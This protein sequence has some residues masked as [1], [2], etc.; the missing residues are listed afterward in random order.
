VSQ[1]IARQLRDAGV[2][3][4]FGVMGDGNMH[5]LAEYATLPGVRWCPAWHEA[6]AVGMADGYARAAGRD[7]AGRNSVGVAT[8]TMGPGLAQALA[9]LTAA[10]RTRSPVLVITAEPDHVSP[11]NAQDVDQQSWAAV[12]GARYRLVTEPADLGRALAETMAWARSGHPAV[13]A[14]ALSLMEKEGDSEAPPAARPTRTNRITGLEPAARLLAASR[15][16]L[17]LLGR[18]AELSGAVPAAVELGRKIG[19]CFL[20]TVPA[21][22]CLAD[23]GDPFDLG[24]TGTMAHP[25]ARRLAAEADVVL[26]V[27]TDLD[28][29]NTAG[30]SFFGAAHLIRI[31]IR[32]PA[33]LWH[34]DNDVTQITADATTALTQL[35]PQLPPGHRN[36]LRTPETAKL[37]AAEPARRAALAAAQPADGLNPWAV[38]AAI[39]AAVC[40]RAHLMTGVGHF[41]YFAAPYLSARPGRTF[42]FGYGFGLIG[43]GLPLAIGAAVANRPTVVIEGD[44]SFLMNP[45]ELQSAVRFGADLLVIVLNNEAYGS[46][47]HK[48]AIADLDPSAGAF[49]RPADLVAIAR[50]LG[51]D[52]RRADTM[53]ELRAGLAAFASCGGVRVLDVAIARSVMSEAYQR[54]HVR[55]KLPWSRER[56]DDTA[57]LRTDRAGPGRHRGRPAARGRGRRG[58]RERGRPDL[59]G[60]KGHARPG[61][62]HDPGVRGPDLRADDRSRPGP[63]GPG[64]DG[65]PEHRA[66]GDRVHR[67]RRRAGRDNHWH[68]RRRPGQDDHPAGRPGNHGAGYRPA[69][70]RLPAA[71]PPRWRAAPGRAHRGRGGPGHPGRA[72]ARR[73]H[74]RDHERRRDTRPA[75]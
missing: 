31:D 10:V 70:A 14:V 40:D 39:D 48:L 44:G 28:A 5:W 47:F 30:G 33:Q 66:D 6:G 29:H 35:A 37:L 27:G 42:Q 22:G 55:T 38:I 62:V 19:A 45:Q 46:E 54:M 75:A 43:Q 56:A 3:V 25:P 21:K 49:D 24:L 72:A 69:R 1:V 18:G 15:R 16:P 26:V 67:L 4:V 2:A 52:A 12:A 34:P 74:L 63:A 32:P 68:L 20:T 41:W 59:R 51:A 71:R 17:V 57:K 60:R 7:G 36:G 61:D 50:A 23:A 53:D 11:P 65:Q 13:L 58:P 73:G 9:A 8:V 64:P